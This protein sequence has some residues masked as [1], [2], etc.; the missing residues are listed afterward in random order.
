[1][2]DTPRKRPGGRTARTG[3]AVHDA[4]RSLMDERG[5]DGFTGRDVAERAG[6]NEATIY[7]RWGT[8]D[9]LMLDVAAAVSRLNEKSPIP[10]TGS[11]RE[12]LR[13]WGLAMTAGLTPPGELS[14]LRTVLA[15]RSADTASQEQSQLIADFLAARTAVIQQVLDRAVARGETA[16]GVT[17]VLDRFVA[18]LYLRAVFGYGD[19]H[20]DLDALIDNTLLGPQDC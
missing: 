13:Q 16:P 18:P 11:L 10:D 15:A 4:V 6:V 14:L 5:P 2:P 7:R 20:S 9:N 17:A 3:Q 8:L 19:L 1:M 12:D